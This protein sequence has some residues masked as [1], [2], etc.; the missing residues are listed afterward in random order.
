[1]SRLPLKISPK[2]QTDFP[3]K[4]TLNLMNNL[5]PCLS[6]ASASNAN[7]YLQICLLERLISN[8]TCAQTQR[9]ERQVICSWYLRFLHRL[10]A[11]NVDLWWASPRCVDV[12]WRRWGFQMWLSPR[13]SAWPGGIPWRGMGHWKWEDRASWAQK[14]ERPHRKKLKDGSLLLS[15][16]WPLQICL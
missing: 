12:F 11:L 7:I 16:R 8:K 9:E 15:W 2:F 5:R 3:N 1:M 13:W 4:H 10:R 6:R 14:E